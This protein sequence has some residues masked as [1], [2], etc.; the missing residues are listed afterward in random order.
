MEFTDVAPPSEYFWLVYSASKGDVVKAQQVYDL[1][2]Y[3]VLAYV[4]THL[5]FNERSSDG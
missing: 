3:H 1:P 2:L 4:D 5:K